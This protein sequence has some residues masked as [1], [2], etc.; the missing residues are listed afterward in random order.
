MALPATCANYPSTANC[1]V[2]EYHYAMASP[3]AIRAP[4]I[5][6]GPGSA[7]ATSW[8]SRGTTVGSTG[9]PAYGQSDLV[10]PHWAEH[11]NIIDFKESVHAAA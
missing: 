4:M 1:R 10:G 8:G 2:L 3:P 9:S 11:P 6:G 5:A 7:A